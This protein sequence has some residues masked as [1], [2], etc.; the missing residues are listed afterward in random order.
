MGQEMEGKT[1]TS[2]E[3]K[4]NLRLSTGGPV[5]KKRASSSVVCCCRCCCYCSSCYDGGC[6]S[7]SGRGSASY[8]YLVNWCNIYF[9]LRTR[10]KGQMCQNFPRDALKLQLTD[11]LWVSHKG[12]SER[13]ETTSSLSLSLLWMFVRR[14]IPTVSCCL[15]LAVNSTRS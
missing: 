11:S 14:Q 7:A 3:C 6:S 4:C 13:A 10:F 8:S 5:L 1:L 12:P 15:R 2:F 9:N